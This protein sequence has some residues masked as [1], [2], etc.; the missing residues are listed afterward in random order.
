MSGRY[1]FVA[2]NNGTASEMNTYVMDGIPYK[3]VAG[4]ATVTGSLAVTFASS[5]TVAPLVL[6]GYQSANNTGTSAT[7]STPTNTGMTIYCWT[8]TTA[9]TVAK[10]VSFMALQMTPTTGNGN[11]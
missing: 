1:T 6:L 3:I 5:F 2:G 4:N 9:T 11:S 10:T 8:G 7:T